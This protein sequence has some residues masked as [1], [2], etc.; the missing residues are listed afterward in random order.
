MAPAIA[1]RQTVV[2]HGV[3][4]EA[5]QQIPGEHLGLVYH[6]ALQLCRT[7]Q[8]DVELDELVS[9]GTIGLIEA[10]IDFDPTRGLA[11]STFAAPRLRGAML[12]ELRRQDHVP[13]SVRRRATELHSAPNR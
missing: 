10:F 13:R 6:V 9:T 3:S 7:K 4:V 1:T 11:L 5:R 12:D 2:N 8:M